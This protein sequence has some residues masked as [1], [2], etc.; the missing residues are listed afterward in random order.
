MQTDL[1]VAFPPDK[2]GGKKLYQGFSQ[3]SARASFTFFFLSPDTGTWTEDRVEDAGRFFFLPNY[4]YGDG[5]APVLAFT[6]AP[7]ERTVALFTQWCRGQA[8]SEPGLL[9]AKAFSAGG[10]EALYTVAAQQREQYFGLLQHKALTWAHRPVLIEADGVED[11]K[12]VYERVQDFNRGVENG[13]PEIFAALQSI[14]ALQ[15][16]RKKDKALLQFLQQEVNNLRGYNDELRAADDT[17]K[18]LKFYHT[19]YEVLPLWYK[20]F[21]HVIKILMGKRKLSF[22]SNKEER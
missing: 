6:E 20:R 5:A 7:A 4:H 12:R 2:E 15:E 14:A 10:Q 17:M 22:I 16:E 19:Q 1:A 3:W 21:G 9:V 8:L 11:V 13:Q 18:I